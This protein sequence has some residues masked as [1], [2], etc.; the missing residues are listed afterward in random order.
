MNSNNNRVEIGN[1]LIGI[2]RNTKHYVSE[3][4]DE[5]CFLSAYQLAV[6]L[7][8]HHKALIRNVNCPHNIGGKG[9]GEHSS[10]AQYVARILAED[11]RVEIGFFNI[12]GL[13]QFS[14]MD[15]KKILSQPSNQCFSMFRYKINME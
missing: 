9:E 8:K 2:L 4:R 6:L 14:F 3:T 5:T 15:E 1:A 11:S 7:N 13:E 10:L 12:E